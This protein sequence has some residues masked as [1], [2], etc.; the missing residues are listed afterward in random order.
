[1]PDQ[2]FDI[3]ETAR[4]G[5]HEV[6]HSFLAP[7]QGLVSQS[8]AVMDR[9][10]AI[11]DR[12]R[13]SQHPHRGLVAAGLLRD[14]AGENEAR[15][16]P[17]MARQDGTADLLRLSDVAGAM[18]LQRR[19]ESGSGIEASKRRC[20]GIASVARVALASDPSFVAFHDGHDQPSAVPQ[21]AN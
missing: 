13:L 14:A 1:M 15:H 2:P 8:E 19:R 7:P 9:G 4:D 21:P 18:V 3:T 16:V 6:P 10:A 20:G 5:I 12:Q 11:V 17:G